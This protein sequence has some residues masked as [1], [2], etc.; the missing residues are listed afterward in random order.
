L[1]SAV[2]GLGL[3]GH[4][5]RLR[6]AIRHELAE[7]GRTDRQVRRPGS[8][9][10]ADVL[11]SLVD[12]RHKLLRLHYAGHISE[13]QFGREQ[14]RLSVQI[15]AMRAAEN[16]ETAER[17]RASDVH[18]QF[19]A[20]AAHLADLDV[21]TLWDAATEVE[22]RVLIDEMIE[23]VEVHDDHLEVTVRGAPKLNV[24]LAEVGLGRQGEF[25]SCRRSDA[26]PPPPDLRHP[27]CWTPHSLRTRL[28]RRRLP[29]FVTFERPGAGGT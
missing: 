19:E 16:T 27:F 21:E 23:A 10:S 12:E 18:E 4:D 24:T 7:A 6:E 26:K 28:S 11:A 1:R 17:E 25:Q 13:E 9:T 14:G 8:P 2:L 15:E 5:E 3:I 22:Q 20:I 29:H